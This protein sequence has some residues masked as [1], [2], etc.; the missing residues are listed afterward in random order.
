MA[1][2]PKHGYRRIVAKFGTNLL[3]AGTDRLDAKLMASLVAQVVRLLGEGRE[4]LVVTSGAIAAGRERLNEHGHRRDI[5]FRQVLASVGQA[6]LMQT[7]DRLFAAHGRVVGQTLLTRRDLADRGGYL[8]ARNT[9][10]GLLDLGVVPVINENDAV[11]TDEIAGAKI[12]DNDNLS[13]LVANLIDADLLALLTD[14][15]GLFSADP[16]V[17]K[18][19]QVIE[20]VERIT[21]EIEA[22]AGGSDSGRGTG[23]MVTK[24]QA[25]RLATGH[26]SDVFI[27]GGHERNVLYRLG[28]GEHA[29]TLFPRRTSR[30]ESRKRWMVSGLATKGCIIVDAG[31]AKAL[32]ERK[33]SLLPAGVRSVTGTFKRGDGV[34]ICLPDNSTIACGITNY[35]AEEIALIQGMRSD[36]IEEALGYQYGS[37]VV[38]RNNLVVL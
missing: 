12:G 10:L 16:R 32:V 9:L 3:T 21:K 20:R 23:G 27:A 35:G 28:N 33:T 1:A 13:A 17:D 37:E 29:G 8:N 15:G 19:A 36:K 30:M 6:H 31:A 24:L 2:K 26:G 18:S 7:Y 38:H 5:P 34:S 14:T 22:I 4:V 25:A 11:A